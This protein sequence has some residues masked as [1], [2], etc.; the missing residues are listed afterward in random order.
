MDNFIVSARK[1]RPAS[2]DTV[3]G[4]LSITSTLRN[5]IMN[6]QLAQAYLFCGPGGRQD[7]VCPY[8]RQDYK[9]HEFAGECRALQ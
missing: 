5:A 6:H 9:L 4:Q 7:D 8:F 2:F 3:V 1:Y